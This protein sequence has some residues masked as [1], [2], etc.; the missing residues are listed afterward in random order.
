MAQRLR[1][2]SRISLG[3][4]DSRQSFNWTTNAT[5]AQT[6][7]KIKRKT[8]E[9]KWKNQMQEASPNYSRLWWFTSVHFMWLINRRLFWLVQRWYYSDAVGYW[10]AKRQLAHWRV[11]M[12]I[13]IHSTDQ[14]EINWKRR[15][16]VH[17]LIEAKYVSHKWTRL[18]GVCVGWC[19]PT[20]AI[21]HL[22]VSQ[23]LV[24]NHH[25]YYSIVSAARAH[26]N[27]RLHHNIWIKTRKK[28]T[29]W[30]LFLW[31]SSGCMA[32]QR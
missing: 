31:K 20:V 17:P 30:K 8:H 5:I 26:S 10:R 16:N 18:N 6:R 29:K 9:K 15:K 12:S 7:T 27:C 3:I 25:Y 32:R 1:I 23:I 11:N 24:L 19:V 4:V 2:S 21:V 13:S 28:T 14:S 22:P